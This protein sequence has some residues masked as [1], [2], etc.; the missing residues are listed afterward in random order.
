MF[1]HS[2]FTRPCAKRNP[3]YLASLFI[4]AKRLVFFSF[5]FGFLRNLR[6]HDKPC[7]HLSISSHKPSKC[8]F[9]QLWLIM[10]RISSLFLCTYSCVLSLCLNFFS[11]MNQH[12]GAQLPLLHN[13]GY[14]R[15]LRHAARGRFASGPRLHEE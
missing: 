7:S 11:N 12:Q 8:C 1:V 6:R 9:G 15:G 3:V 14:S 4:C 13:K 10:P 5:N 2:D